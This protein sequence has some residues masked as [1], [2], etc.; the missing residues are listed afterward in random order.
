MDAAVTSAGLE[1][2]AAETTL[3]G[4][5]AVRLK[6]MEWLP[7]PTSR[8]CM[9]SGSRKTPRRCSFISAR[10]QSPASN[11]HSAFCSTTT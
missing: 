5:I 1:C 10:P 2:E 4:K 9:L 11:P 8:S 3:P 7:P 6:Y